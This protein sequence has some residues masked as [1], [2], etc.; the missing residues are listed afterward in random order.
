MFDPTSRE[1]SPTARFLLTTLAI[2]AVFILFAFVIPTP[3]I[4]LPATDQAEEGEAL[5]G[6]VTLV[7]SEETALVGGTTFRLY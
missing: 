7:L 1:G 3:E 2:A 5:A 6:R 4:P